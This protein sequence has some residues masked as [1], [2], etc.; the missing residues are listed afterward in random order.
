MVETRE[1]SRDYPMPGGVVHAVR[2]VSI[3]VGRG[4]LVALRG[5]SGSGK[6]TF[7]SM[8]GALDRP[9]RGSVS[10]RRAAGLGAARVGAH[11][12]PPAEGRLHLPGVRAAC[13]SCPPRRTSRCRSDSSA[14]TRGSAIGASASCSSWSASASAP[15]TG[16]TS[17]PAA[18][19]SAWR[20][21]VRSPTGRTCSWPTSRPASSTRRPG[22]A[23]WSCSST[24]MLQRGRHGHRGDPRH[25]AHR[26]RRPGHR[27]ARRPG[28]RWRATRIV[29]GLNPAPSGAPG[30][31]GGGAGKGRVQVRLEPDAQ[32][33]PHRVDRHAV[34]GH[35]VLI[36]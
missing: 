32:I 3:R 6:T 8:V 25:D 2:D 33:A 17:S 27:A 31:L 9:T 11:R 12:V 20:S 35:R 4:Q 13:R 34:L 14:P 1:L 24:S 28:G 22:A 21:P 18:S 7:L 16:R 29:G 15:T 23:S 30:R 19:S 10:R 5:R 36:A 26:P